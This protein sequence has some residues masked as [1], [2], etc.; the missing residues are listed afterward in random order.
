[1]SEY[2]DIK[3]NTYTIIQRVLSG[4]ERKIYTEDEILTELWRIFSGTK[5]M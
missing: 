2:K 3:N 4:D 5:Q 1:M